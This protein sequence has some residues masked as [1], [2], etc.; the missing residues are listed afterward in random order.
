MSNTEKERILLLESNHLATM[1]DL[2]ELKTDNKQIKSSVEKIELSI[3]SLPEKLA[4]KFD[5]RYAN[6][7]TEV[8]LKR[9]NWLVVS[10]VVIALLALLINKP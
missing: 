6:K 3:A 4:N 1:A 9:L 8:S 10:S 5:E 2:K 7:E